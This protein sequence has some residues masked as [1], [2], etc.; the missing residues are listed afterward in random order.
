MTSHYQ[1]YNY[2]CVFLLSHLTKKLIIVPAA[3]TAS[4]PKWKAPTHVVDSGSDTNESTD[5]EESDSDSCDIEDESESENNID[6]D[7]DP[8][9][10][11]STKRTGQLF[12][13]KIMKC[14]LVDENGAVDCLNVLYL[15]PKMEPSTPLDILHVQ[16]IA[17]TGHMSV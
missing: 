11:Y 17:F 13:S 14:F 1:S 5:L 3:A 15:K 12:V 4:S 10:V 8:I 6:E 2:L 7:Q 16:S 9:K